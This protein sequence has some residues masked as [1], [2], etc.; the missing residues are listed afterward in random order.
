MDPSPLGKFRQTI[1]M[2]RIDKIMPWNV[3]CTLETPVGSLDR[4]IG[5]TKYP[6]RG[7][8]INSIDNYS[9]AA[10]QLFASSQSEDKR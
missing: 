9:A 7:E 5:S 8:S 2:E 6:P 1:E 3:A 4:T 10:A